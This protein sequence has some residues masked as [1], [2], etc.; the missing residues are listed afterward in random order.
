MSD[1][2]QRVVVDGIDFSRMVYFPKMLTAVGS[3]LHPPRLVLA[4]FMIF[5]FM[6]VGRLWDGVT[7]PTVSPVG[8]VGGKVTQAELDSYDFTVREALQR[9]AAPDH[10]PEGEARSWHEL[11]SGD[12]IRRMT[13]GYRDLRTKAADT[14]GQDSRDQMFIASV[15]RVEAARPLGVF[16]AAWDHLARAQGRIVQGVASLSWD[17]ML[18]GLDELF[19]Q[20]PVRLWNVDKTFTIVFGLFVLVVFAL[21]GG[22][23]SRLT[24]THF[25]N[26]E[27]LH[28][29]Q[30]V[31]FAVVSWQKLVLAQVLPLILALVL[32]LFLAVCGL[33]LWVPAVD[34]L[35]GL[36]YGLA[37]LVGF[38]VAVVVIGYI[39][40]FSLLTPA[41]ACEN[42]D[43]AEAMQRAYA[44]VI[45]R[46]LHFAGYALLGVIGWALGMLIVTL[47]ASMTIH[48]TGGLTG[49]WQDNPAMQVT[50]DVDVLNLTGLPAHELTYID[51][52]HSRWT[53]T[54]ISFWQTIV[55]ALACAYGLSYY[56]SAST[57]MYLL[58]RRAC[59]GQ[60][61][62]D[63]WAGEH[64][65]SEG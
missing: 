63:V 31:D 3:A 53:A 61:I 54:L 52:W 26:G 47:V 1:T 16:E 64:P 21:G 19:V 38:C 11:S 49:M 25:A 44:Y 65:P 6:G 23:I 45:L 48:Y 17:T 51:S 2:K 27:R 40:G 43:A 14:P 42:C 22:A 60:A 62:D 4:L 41:V 56:F 30:A 24:A 32:G 18:Q 59:D 20:T 58:L 28:M 29:R 12:V 15:K 7:S 34:V 5:V 36:I 13:A 55:A 35:A 9:Y 33:L 10:L 57:V 46:P 50:H 39:A 8:L 37:I